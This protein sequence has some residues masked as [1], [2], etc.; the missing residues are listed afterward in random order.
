MFTNPEQFA[1][2]TKALF[3][4]QLETFNTLTSKTVQGVE[5]VIALNLATA[6]SNLEG[7]L[8]AGKA[9]SAA[10]D[11]KA[12]LQAA[13]ENMQPGVA[14]AAAYNQQLGGIIADIREEFTRAADAHMTEARN[15]LSALIHDVTKNVRPGSENAVQIVKTAIDNAFAGYE[16][17]TKATR[18]A[19]EAVEAEIAKANALVAQ[20]A[21]AKK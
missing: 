17:V 7:G 15:N 6:K 1:N 21:A 19:V 8:A 9:I 5:Q 20:G 4:F 3:E 2:A 13:A 18:Q 11:P 16:Q 14:G 10:P 12:A